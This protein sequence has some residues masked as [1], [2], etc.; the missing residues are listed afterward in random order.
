MIVLFFKDKIHFI[1]R[2]YWYFRNLLQ[3]KNRVSEKQNLGLKQPNAFN[4]FYINLKPC[5]GLQFSY[6]VKTR[7]QL[8]L[9]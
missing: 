6:I 4:Y 2:N 8:L 3:K 5:K 1:L 7:R 9:Q